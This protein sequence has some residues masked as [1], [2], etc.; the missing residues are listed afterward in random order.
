[1]CVDWCKYHHLI[2]WNCGSMLQS[3]LPPLPTE[4]NSST[5]VHYWPCESF[6]NLFFKV[7]FMFPSQVFLSLNSSHPACLSV[8][9]VPSHQRLHSHN[10]PSTC[11]CLHVYSPHWRSTNISLILIIYMR[12]CICHTNMGNWVD[13]L[14]FSRILLLWNEMEI[15]VW[16]LLLRHVIIML[17]TNYVKD[18]KKSIP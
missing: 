1:M 11:V 7:D 3:P 15:L 4:K 16:H 14:Y 9:T 17:H 18:F 6:S 2:A 5:Q 12:K 13:A 8:I 10:F